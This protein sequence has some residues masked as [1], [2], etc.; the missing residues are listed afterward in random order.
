M[1][2]LFSAGSTLTRFKSTQS[3]AA[4]EKKSV[5]PVKSPIAP[6]VDLKRAAWKG[7]GVSILGGFQDPAK[8]VPDLTMCW[9]EPSVRG[10]QTTLPFLW[11]QYLLAQFTAPPG[12]CLYSKLRS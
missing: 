7:G 11:H 10:C 4:H 3:Q 6:L 12:L 8:V 9:Q 2:P 5:F 1:T